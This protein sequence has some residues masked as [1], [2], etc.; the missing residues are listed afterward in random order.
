ML[1]HIHYLHGGLFS[2][3]GEWIHP[4]RVLDNTEII[5]VQKGTVSIGIDGEPFDAREGDVLRLDRGK[6]HRGLRVTGEPVSFYWF[7]FTGAMPTDWLN[8]HFSM[9]EPYRADVLCR[10]LLHYANTPVYPAE[11]AQNLFSVLLAE[12]HAQSD[13]QSDGS[14]VL[15]EVCAWIRAHDSCALTSADTAARFGYNAD[16]LS[17]LFRE[18]FG[19]GLKQYL[20]NVRMKRIKTLLLSPDYSLQQIA[21]RTGFSDY[22]Y[23]LKFFTLHE[24]ATPTTFRSLYFNTHTNVQ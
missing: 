21:E 24:G 12:L 13:A 14:R 11:T 2:S 10:Q 4:E 19:Y 18:Q 23:F 6:M 1:E 20:V 9:T 7:H 22:K 16:Y 8:T 5:L 3:E 17:R 15:G